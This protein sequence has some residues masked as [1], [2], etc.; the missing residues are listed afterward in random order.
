MRYE[1]NESFFDIMPISLA[2]QGL[3]SLMTWLQ[4]RVFYNG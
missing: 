2:I 4:K 1:K 3:F